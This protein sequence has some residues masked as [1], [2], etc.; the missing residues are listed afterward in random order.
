MIRFEDSYFVKFRFTPQQ[1]AD[2]FASVEKDLSIARDSK[3][4]E[5][6]F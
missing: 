5:V 2:Y 6:I 3:V 1:I 4:P